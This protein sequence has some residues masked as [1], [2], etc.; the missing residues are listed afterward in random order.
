[1]DDN[2]IIE[3]YWKRDQSAIC[4][5]QHK[6]GKLCRYVAYNILHN[7]EDV[8][9]CEN[10]TYNKAWE[11]IP[12]QRPSILSAFLSKIARN[13]AIDKYRSKTAKKRGNGQYDIVI[14][15]LYECIPVL[16]NMEHII[17]DI[18]IKDSLNQFLE[19]LPVKTR[20]IFMRRY[21][22]MSSIKEIA[23]DFSMSESNIKMTLL[24]TRKELKTF[25]EKEG[26]N[27]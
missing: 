19:K 26:I 1:M 13:L 3:L 9:E 24:R 23:T 5:T 4:E 6:Y 16:D 27:I 15:E 21:W 14:D 12:P 10:D 20:K 18:V 22:Y 25:L 2:Q 11:M 8:K 7:N 17:E